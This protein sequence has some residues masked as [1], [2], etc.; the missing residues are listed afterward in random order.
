M[1]YFSLPAPEDN[2]YRIELEL[3]EGPVDLLLYLIKKNEIDIY[4]IPIAKIA[5][6]FV[7]YIE[8]VK[9]LNL[10]I[11]GEYLLMA[12]MLLRIKVA[13]L[14][15]KTSLLS[16]EKIEDPREEL[17]NL[18]LEYSRYRKMGEALARRYSKQSKFYPRGFIELSHHEE[19]LPV[20]RID[21][22]SLMQAAWSVLKDKERNVFIPD[23]D[24]KITVSDRSKHILD[25]LK[26]K[27]RVSFSELFSSGD[28]KLLI[29][30]TLIALLELARKGQLLIAQS[31]SFTP[32]WVFRRQKRNPD[33]EFN[34]N[35]EENNQ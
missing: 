16:S 28:S 29:V 7:D 19:E 2:E 34:L 5:A 8:N 35:Y 11:A 4:D 9:K 13:T 26:L 32:L 23:P 24:E 12:S 10:N 22:V 33:S 21:L 27:R 20:F 31:D 15:P 6:Q 3:F 17:V 25:K 30:V 1:E 18:L 14:L